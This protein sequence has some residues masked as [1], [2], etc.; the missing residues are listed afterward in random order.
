MR[1]V[2]WSRSA[3]I[4]APNL[5][6][7]S[8]S[9]AMLAVIFAMALA[10]LDTGAAAFFGAGFDAAFAKGFA[11]ALIPVTTFAGAVVF[12]V[13]FAALGADFFAVAIF[14]IHLVVS[15]D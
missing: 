10:A 6:L 13:V 14:N 7:R 12:L 11:M 1:A 4:S 2:R 8:V 9:L 15:G 3:L 5:F